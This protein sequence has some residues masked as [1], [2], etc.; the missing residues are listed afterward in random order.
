MKFR[1][2]YEDEFT[3][4]PL[5]D[6]HQNLWIFPLLLE[7][8]D[9][10]WALLTEAAV[11]GDY[12][13][14]I[15]SSEKAD[16]AM[17]RLTPPPDDFGEQRVPAA[18]PWRVILAG[19][20]DEIVNSSVIESLNPAAAEGFP[21]MEPDTS[22]IQPGLVAWSWMTENDSPGDFLRQKDFIDLAARMGWPYCLVDGGWR[23]HHVNIPAR[24]RVRKDEGV[25]IWVWEHQ[26][27][28][29]DRR[30]TDKFF[31]RLEVWGV[32]G[33]KID[34]FE[35]DTRERIAKY[36]MFAEEARAII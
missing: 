35:S 9:G 16:P 29:P 13:G 27:N 32:A 20:L 15:L 7:E 11:Y 28:L 5:E 26:H 21:P 34:F 22:Y 25:R 10:V 23:Q 36:D 8:E 1:F 2:T 12:G 3:R 17:L 18:T 6:L 30:E 4:V 33:V 14:H 31:H 24:G 19:S